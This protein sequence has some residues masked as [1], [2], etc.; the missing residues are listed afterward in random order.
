MI[1]ESTVKKYCCED[2]SLIENYEEAVNSPEM[3]DCHHRLEIDEENEIVFS[4]NELID[5]GYYYNRPAKELIFFR[6]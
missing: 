1:S 2:I 6:M 3:Y 4:G 5:L